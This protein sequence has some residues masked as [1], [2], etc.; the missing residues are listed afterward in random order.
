MKEK[1]D[2]KCIFKWHDK[3]IW[4]KNLFFFF[5]ELEWNHKVESFV[6][7]YKLKMRGFLGGV[8]Q[9]SIL[10]ISKIKVS[11]ACWKIIVD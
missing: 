7:R 1:H 2:E 11:K 6:D 9:D 5:A 10:K 8:C 4:E 3:S